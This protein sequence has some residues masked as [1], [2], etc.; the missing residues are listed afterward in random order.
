MISIILPKKEA[1]PAKGLFA[2][3]RIFAFLSGASSISGSP[4]SPA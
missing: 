3:C 1:Y 4:F 2:T